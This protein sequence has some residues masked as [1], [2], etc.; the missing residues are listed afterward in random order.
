M[1][2]RK[3]LTPVAFQQLDEAIGAAEERLRAETRGGVG[4]VST[5]EIVERIHHQAMA[6]CRAHMEAAV[7]SLVSRR[8]TEFFGWKVGDDEEKAE[9]DAQPLL[10]GLILPAFFS[11]PSEDGSAAQW[12]LNINCTPDD[13]ALVLAHRRKLVAAYGKQLTNVQ[14][15]RETALR[16]GCKPAQPISSVGIGGNNSKGTP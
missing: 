6:I 1:S 7:D 11:V 16:R 14:V 5:K 13:L 2:N 4:G 9:E 3:R 15:L 8:V 10:P 12:K